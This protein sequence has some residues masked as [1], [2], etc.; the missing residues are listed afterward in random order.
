[1]LREYEASNTSKFHI[2]W[3]RVAIA[4]AGTSVL[5][6]K[7]AEGIRDS[8]IPST[9]DFEKIV[10]TIEDVV[11]TIHDR[12][13][14][15][16]GLDYQLEALI[17]GLDKFDKGDPYLRVVHSVGVTE[18]IENF[19]II[20]HGAPYVAPFYRL[21]YD[22][23]LTVNELAVLGYF[24]VSTIIWLGLDQ[25]VGMNQLGP[26]CVV[27]RANEQPLFLNPLDE[28]FKTARESLEQLK[29]RSKLVTSIWQKIPQ[30]F[31]AMLLSGQLP[32]FKQEELKERAI[33][34]KLEIDG[35]DVWLCDSCSKRVWLP[36]R[37]KAEAHHCPYCG[38][39][40]VKFER[41]AILPMY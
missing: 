27:L 37:W 28:E 23:M 36:T 6:D 24:A 26:E 14:E 9:P 21:F 40:K 19:A 34:Q 20:G 25:S 8:Q 11:R 2:L 33:L 31:E 5:L 30:A 41:T 22:P 12:Y 29:F 39:N 4:G 10:Q 1:M 13:E 38:S 15:R 17:T 18:H 3:D 7:F 35:F 32:D 16:L